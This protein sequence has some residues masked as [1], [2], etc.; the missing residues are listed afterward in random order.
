[1]LDDVQ[2]GFARKRSG[3]LVLLQRIPTPIV[4]LA[5][6]KMAILR[7]HG[8]WWKLME[9]NGSDL[10]N[11][12]GSK[13]CM[14]HGLWLALSFARWECITLR[15]GQA[16]F[17]TPKTL[18]KR[19]RKLRNDVLCMT[20]FILVEVA[21]PCH[22]WL[23]PPHLDFWAGVFCGHA[24]W[25]V[26][27]PPPATA[28]LGDV[29]AFYSV[30]AA[31]WEAFCGAVGD[32]GQDLRVLASMPPQML[33]EGVMAART[34][35]GRRL[36]PVE[37]IQ[38]G[39]TY[40]ACHRLVHLMAGGS[41]ATWR[42]PDPWTTP[43]SSSSTAPGET[44]TPGSTGATPERKMKLSQVAD[45]GDESEFLVLPEASKAKYY[46][47]YVA[48]VGGMP[49]DAED[50]TVEQ[51][52]AIV[53]KVFTLGQPPYCDFAVW[54][55]FAKRHLKAQKYQSFV[56]QDDGSFL[57]KMVPGPAC[58]THWQA[59][60]RVLRTT[61]VM[62]EVVSLANLM[63]WEAMVERLNRQHPGCWGLIAAAEDRARGEYMSKTLARVRLEIEQGAAQPLGW[64]NDEP[65]DIIWGKV[66]RDKEYWS[67][68]VHVPAIA[69]T[70]RGQRGKPLS[71]MEEL[72]DNAMRG[73]RQAL[74]PEMEEQE[75]DAGGRKKNKTRREARKRKLRADKEEL[76]TLRKGS[77]GGGAKGSG[78]AGSKGG[79][80]G[81]ACYAW[82]NGNGLCGGLPPGEPC[83][84][85]VTRLHHCTQCGSPGH[86]SKSC[87]AS[88]KSWTGAPGQAG[89]SCVE[90]QGAATAR[91]GPKRNQR[92]SRGAASQGGTW[93][94]SCGGPQRG[95]GSPGTTPRAM[96]SLPETRSMCG[97]DT[98]P[99]RST[100][101]CASSTSSTTSAARWTI[102]AG[103]WW[104]NPRSWGSPWKPPRWTSLQGRIY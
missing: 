46:T 34:T 32:P 72:A 4:L 91:A 16:R 60:Y 5:G 2:I 27:W 101:K 99:S 25:A 90:A 11:L 59:S 15:S 84:A 43:S 45:Q 81:E 21:W 24:A 7:L 28:L 87:P 8:C 47:K 55:P 53:R 100:W 50:P 12:V 54:V 1:M 14:D 44:T 38:V 68:Q 67:E 37:A 18:K 103:R 102:S 73:G 13:A 58:F 88:K 20:R 74:Q 94:R 104:R 42:D 93:W 3:V 64:N 83:K 40:R 56:L 33:A 71:P 30:P 78:N 17:G 23:K 79:A 51:I 96:R 97:G 26:M 82:N 36:T 48:K 92:K 63:E 6:V 19:E 39:M 35:G 70:A 95:E 75:G 57:A 98:C 66:L 41:Q 69:W 89:P 86:P 65:W 61:L 52:S 77:K 22:F 62:T 10:K 80:S 49:A 31:V 85:K 29:L 9:Q 76:Q